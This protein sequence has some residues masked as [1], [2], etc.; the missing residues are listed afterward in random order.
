[1]IK[2]L[3]AALCLCA[4]SLPAA[5][6]QYS[7][8]DPRHFSFL[9]DKELVFVEPGNTGIE[10]FVRG[11]SRDAGALRPWQD[12]GCNA[13]AVYLES[14]LYHFHPQ[15]RD[16]GPDTDGYW[17]RLDH[18]VRAASMQG[19]LS[20]FVVDDDFINT[21]QTHPH[22]ADELTSRLLAYRTQSFS[23]PAV[24]YKT[25]TW[26]NRE[27][28]LYAR[29]QGPQPA[30]LSGSYYS[31]NPQTA[32]GPAGFAIVEETRVPEPYRGQAISTW[33]RRT[34]GQMPVIVACHKP[35]FLR[36][37]AWIA[38][39]VNGIWYPS[40]AATPAE[41]E[42]Q[43][44]HIRASSAF[45]NR[46]ASPVRLAPRSPHPSLLFALHTH[47]GDVCWG[48]QSGAHATGLSIPA[49][50]AGATTRGVWFNPATD[51]NILQPLAIAPPTINLAP[52]GDGTW[53]YSLTPANR[54]AETATTVSA[55]TDWRD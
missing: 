12:T 44:R 11:G 2:R 39:G 22:I 24:V 51:E 14:P 34:Y 52:P 23:Q 40:M 33:L 46:F 9:R 27:Q 18:F 10:L 4:A 45:Y 35:D 37:L 16:N 20:L 50:L 42:R 15:D 32:R 8:G 38:S 41:N 3:C 5:E 53:L 54:A 21:W 13:R 17:T 43:W 26:G 36:E 7:S 30:A 6:L 31:A 19:M 48:L 28:A 55:I 49:A 47:T 25:S 29:L 1:M